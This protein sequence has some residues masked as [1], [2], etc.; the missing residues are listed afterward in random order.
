MKTIAFFHRLELTDLFAPVAQALEGRAKIVHLAYDDH[1]VATLRRLGV[2]A[3]VL[4]ALVVALAA[5][6][7]YLSTVFFIGVEG[8]GSLA[9][10]SG[11]P[12]KVGPVPLHAVYRRSVVT[13]DSLSPSARAL[14]DERRLRDREDAMDVSEQLGMWP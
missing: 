1:E 10:Y 6:A 8:D 11:V 14:V 5:G 9:V 2:V 7:F 3:G 13:Y 12:G 4:T